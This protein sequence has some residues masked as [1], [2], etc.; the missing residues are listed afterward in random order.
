MCEAWDGAMLMYRDEGVQ[1]GIEKGIEKGIEALILDNLEDNRSKSVIIDKL[2]RC[3]SLSEKEAEKYY[4]RYAE[5]T[6]VAHCF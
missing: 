3:F 6:S 1:E 4:M 2:Q 5:K